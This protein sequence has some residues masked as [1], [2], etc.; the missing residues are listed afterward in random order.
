MNASVSPR[1][2]EHKHAEG[3][4][5]IAT[6]RFEDGATLLAAQAMR[7]GNPE[8]KPPAIPKRKPSVRPGYFG[9][10]IAS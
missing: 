7:G 9:C 6:A 3:L 4:H 8:Y 5:T 2:T 10:G 1:S